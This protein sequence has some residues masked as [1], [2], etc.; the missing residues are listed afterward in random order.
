M[1]SLFHV[2]VATDLLEKVGWNVI[3]LQKSMKYISLL[4]CFIWSVLEDVVAIYE[5]CFLH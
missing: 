1:F 5:T 2:L 4:L 3:S